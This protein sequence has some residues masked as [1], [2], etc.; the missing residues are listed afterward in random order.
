MEPVQHEIQNATSAQIKQIYKS[1]VLENGKNPPSLYWLAKSAGLQEEEL[2]EYYTTFEAI[3]Q[4]IWK[5]IYADT[6]DRFQTDFAQNTQY[7]AREQLLSF[8]Y[9]W[10]EVLK[11]D[12]SFVIYSLKLS[13]RKEITPSALSGFK[14]EFLL[15][16]KEIVSAGIANGEIEERTLL[17]DKYKDGLWLQLLFVLNF[18]INDNSKGFEKTDAAIEKAVNLSFD[19][20]AR[21]PL[22]AIIDFGRFMIQNR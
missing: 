7:T 1:Y 15:F 22:D 14:K 3:E 6:H 11:K 2:Y 20:M 9:N 21:G 17:S 19:L 12:R 5:D 8:Y 18:W 4:D 13:G 10:I 16:A